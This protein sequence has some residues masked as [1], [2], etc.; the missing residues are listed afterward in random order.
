LGTRETRRRLLSLEVALSSLFLVPKLH[1]GTAAC[2]AVALPP[3]PGET[4]ERTEILH[5]RFGDRVREEFAARGK[6][7][8]NSSF[9]SCTSER[10]PLQQLNCLRCRGDARTN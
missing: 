1:F 10:Q 4:R 7:E 9:R 8:A 5:E 3:L 2:P 6:A